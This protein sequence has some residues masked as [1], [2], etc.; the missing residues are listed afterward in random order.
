MAETG[1]RQE[2]ETTCSPFRTDLLR[3]LFW[4]CGDRALAEDV[5]QETLLR[6]WRSFHS[7][8]D[9]TAARSWLFTIARRE[10][11]RVF[12]RKRLET[13]DIDGLT[14]AE[15]RT[16]AATDLGDVEEM[17]RAIMR[18][19]PAYREPLVLQVLFGY[20]TEEI[21]HHMELSRPAVLSRLFRARQ[22]LRR[23]V[24]GAEEDEGCLS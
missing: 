19:E 3:F 15:Q 16:L 7:L 23:Q 18:L 1:A 13:V 24:L 9:R 4:L 6:A 11:A 17:R 22:H 21:A 2:F 5:M 20:S 14:D 8:E 10:L 12:E